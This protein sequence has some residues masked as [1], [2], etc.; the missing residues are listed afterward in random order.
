MRPASLGLSCLETSRRRSRSAWPQPARDADAA[1]AGHVDEVASGQRDLGAQPGAL[2]AHRVLGDLHEHLLAVLERVADAPGALLALRRRDLVDVQEA[3][4]LEAEVDER[5]VDAAQHVL[6][7]A[8]VDVAQIRLLVRPLDVDLGQAAVLD[9]RD[10]QFL[11]VVGHEDDA[12]AWARSPSRRGA[13]TTARS[14]SCRDRCPR[15][16]GRWPWGGGDHARA[17]ATCRRPVPRPALPPTSRRAFLQPACSPPA[18][19]APLRQPAEPLRPRRCARAPCARRAHRG[20]GAWP[21]WRRRRPASLPLRRPRP[22][23]TRGSRSGAPAAS[24][25]GDEHPL[26]RARLRRRPQRLR[27]P[28][29]PSR[30]GVRRDGSCR[31]ASPTYRTPLGFGTGVR[32]G[33]CALRDLA[34][35][36]GGRRHGLGRRHRVPADASRRLPDFLSG[37][38]GRLGG[39]SGQPDQARRRFGGFGPRPLQRPSPASAR[40][41]RRAPRPPPPGNRSRRA[42]AGP[43]PR[44]RTPRPAV[45][46]SGARRQSAPK[47]PS[48][49]R[50]SAWRPA[51]IRSGTAPRRRRLPRPRARSPR[52]RRRPPCGGACHRGCRDA[53]ACAA[54]RR[55]PR[56]LRRHPRLVQ[57]A[58]AA[59]SASAGRSRAGASASTA[60]V[61]G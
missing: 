49:S 40:P 41:R 53:G 35:G 21:A 3:V 59:G 55:L 42:P 38:P 45:P 5:G 6:D 22:S 7:L 8:L 29:A 23:Q 24:R 33:L 26:P 17:A 12:C 51:P 1:A 34:F 47:A 15:P 31:P 44:S 50:R 52:A 25:F 60:P 2:A 20:G 9:Q 27:R 18:T 36:L 14:S 46:R 13:G 37:P 61:A 30:A 56:L 54:P 39:L 32:L 43:A 58:T 16:D 57:T 4:L 48:G 19:P 10:A 28:R 11:A